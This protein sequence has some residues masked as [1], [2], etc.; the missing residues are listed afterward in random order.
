MMGYRKL[1]MFVIACVVI[2]FVS[3]SP[4]N[5]HAFEVLIV[6]AFGG[7]SIEHL[8]TLGGA[9]REKLAAWGIGRTGGGAGTAAGPEQERRPED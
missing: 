5:G 6:V 2:A 1:I 9:L 8:G 3:L 7:N 4:T